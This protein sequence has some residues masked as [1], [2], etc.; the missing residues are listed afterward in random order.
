MKETKEFHLSFSN[1]RVR[2]WFYFNTPA[3]IIFIVL[4]FQLPMDQKYISS[5]PPLVIGFISFLVDS[6][7]K[8]QQENETN[9]IT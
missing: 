1:K 7:L 8:K 4:T 9:S 3:I 5:I 6:Y 2:Y